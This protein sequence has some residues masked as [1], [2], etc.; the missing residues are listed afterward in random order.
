MLTPGKHSMEPR[1]GD[2]FSTEQTNHCSPTCTLIVYGCNDDACSPEQ[3]YC[4]IMMMCSV[5]EETS[6]S[7]ILKKE[8]KTSTLLLSWC[9]YFI[10][11]VLFFAFFWIANNSKFLFF[12]IFFLFIFL[13][14]FF[15]MEKPLTAHWRDVL[16]SV[17]T[18]WA[19]S[20]P[21]AVT[22]IYL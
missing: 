9:S 15:G 14:L 8:R 21:S 4:L 2:T 5:R 19:L 7:S 10:Y 22:G 17:D 6:C 12:V 11:G 3:S 13:F 18:L 20:D 1:W 16:G